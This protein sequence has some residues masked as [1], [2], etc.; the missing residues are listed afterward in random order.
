MPRLTE[1]EK[2]V[3]DY[4]DNSLSKEIHEWKNIKNGNRDKLISLRK[5]V[6]FCIDELKLE[7]AKDVEKKEKFL[8]DIFTMLNL[9]SIE[10]EHEFISYCNSVRE[11]YSVQEQ[12]ELSYIFNRYRS[13]ALDIDTDECLWNSLVKPIRVLP[14]SYICYRDFV[15]MGVF[16]T[17]KF[18]PQKDTSPHWRDEDW[19]RWS[20]TQEMKGITDKI[21]SSEELQEMNNVDTRTPDFIKK[22]LLS[23]L[24]ADSEEESVVINNIELQDKHILVLP[25]SLTS[26]N[27]DFVTGNLKKL[28]FPNVSAIKNIKDYCLMHS[29]ECVVGGPGTYK[30]KVVKSKGAILGLVAGLLCDKIYHLDFSDD[31]IF[32]G[33]NNVTDAATKTSDILLTEGFVYDEG[34]IKN[35]RKKILKMIG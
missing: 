28:I 6:S 32:G 12:D 30:R 22:M 26:E 8:F 15:E 11:G 34:S 3:I 29:P 25:K 23:G 17:S 18:N 5:E 27:F 9:F 16:R 1:W 24:Y 2:A 13:D 21:F 10:N 4:L 14:E 20:S 7:L 19:E 35:V 31:H 33:I